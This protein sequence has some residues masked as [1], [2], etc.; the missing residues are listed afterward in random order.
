MPGGGLR[1]RDSDR[2]GM[3]V[4]AGRRPLGRHVPDHARNTALLARGLL[5]ASRNAVREVP[6]AAGEA[7]PG[8][9][10]LRVRAKPQGRDGRAVGAGAEKAR[11]KGKEAYLQKGG[12][13]L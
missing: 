12:G 3:L 6:A 10:P 9:A 8:Q 5:E 13:A 2:P 4:L 7:P 1:H 11:T